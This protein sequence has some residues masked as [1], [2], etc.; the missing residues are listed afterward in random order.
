MG[1]PLRRWTE[2]EHPSLGRYRVGPATPARSVRINAVTGMSDA[3]LTDPDRKEALSRAYVG[4]IAAGAGYSTYVPEY[5]RD[6]I[7]LG[8]GAGGA[9]R[10]RLEVQLKATINFSAREGKFKFSLKKKNYD[11]LRVPTQVPRILVVL[12]LPRRQTSWLD[13]SG[14][15]LVL[16]RCA[17]WTSLQGEPELPDGQENRTILIPSTNVFDVEGLKTLMEK[18]RRGV[19]A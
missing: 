13:I 3:I 5:G 18:A 7:D 12:A 16:R 14:K 19:I 10:P 17:Y 1:P 6:S 15:R 9:M 8:F 11:D 4:V 2:S